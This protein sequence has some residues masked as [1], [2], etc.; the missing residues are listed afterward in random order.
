MQRNILIAGLGLILI[1]TLTHSPTK[2]DDNLAINRQ[3]GQQVATEPARSIQ[4][5]PVA[6]PTAGVAQPV[7]AKSYWTVTTTPVAT[8]TVD[9]INTALALY[10]DMGM[11][12]QGAAYLIGNFMGESHLIPCGNYGDGGQAQGLAQW[13]PGRRYDMPCD[14]VEQLKWAV[15]VEMVRDTPALHDVLFDPNADIATIQYQLYR[16]ERWG[17]LG[18]R[19]VYAQAVYNQL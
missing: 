8:A 5:E 2:T 9:K 17:T 7:V 14:Y 4:T 1:L 11:S 3:A 10:Q 13:H 16:W 19:W 6:L 18:A 12:K 15:N